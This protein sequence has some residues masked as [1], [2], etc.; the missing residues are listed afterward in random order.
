[1]EGV[2]VGRHLGVADHHA[3]PTRVQ[4]SG[5][6][7]LR[8]VV[9]GGIGR[10]EGAWEADGG[11]VGFVDVAFHARDPVLQQIGDERLPVTCPPVER[12]PSGGHGRVGDGPVH[13]IHVG[14]NG[15]KHHAVDEQGAHGG[16]RFDV[17]HHVNDQMRSVRC[18]AHAHG[19]GGPSGGEGFRV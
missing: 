9:S 14:A 12:P 5:G 16:G 7:T 19:L 17:E 8:Q 18:R 2:E 3:H 13:P 1:M 4:V 6:M 15:S 10:Q 11:E